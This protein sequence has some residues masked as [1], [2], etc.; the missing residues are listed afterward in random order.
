LSHNDVWNYSSQTVAEMIAN[1][2]GDVL[3]IGDSRL[4]ID[5]ANGMYDRMS[6][7]VRDT[8]AGL[9]YADSAGHPRIDYQAGSI[10]DNFDCGAVLAISVPAAKEALAQ[11]NADSQYQW[12]GLYDLRLRLSE[13][14]PIVRI[15]ETLYASYFETDR[16]SAETQ[17]DY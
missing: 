9:A 17:F 13:R 1:A 2:A 6:Q 11:A 7:I 12:G 14:G 16:P 10:R 8:G 3:V 5:P 15:P 4:Q